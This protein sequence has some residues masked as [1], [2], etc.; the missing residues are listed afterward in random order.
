MKY[1]LSILYIFAIPFLLVAQSDDELIDDL[2]GEESSVV[3]ST[4]K[5]SRVINGHSV[6]QPAKGEMD[7]RISHR[8]GQ[9]NTGSYDLWGLDQA[10]IHFSLEYS[11]LD[12]LTIGIGR[13]SY[14]K[15]YD[16][17]AKL[18]ILK[19]QAGMPFFLSYVA[20]T[21]IVT[22]KNEIPDYE[23]KH[24]VGYVH[25]LLIARKFSKN[26]SLQ[27]S[28]TLVHKNL[29]PEAGM[30]NNIMSLGIGARY[31]LSKRLSVNAETFLTDFGPMPEGIEYHQPI[32]L[33]IDLETGG[34]VFQIMVTNSLP[35]REVG[36]ITETAGD[37]FKGD[38]HLG[39]NISRTFNL[40]K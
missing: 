2:L 6:E 37:F 31:K 13:S 5:T 32:S 3:S 17:Y 28:P 21:E 12:Y 25:Q 4:F 40:H 1:I 22:L 27:L 38:I 39:F 29:V 26:F 10:T 20:T 24:R 23:F 16:G 36:F 19:Q 18:A 34:H 35:M 14:R 11:P 15:T 7:F 33:G 9:L 8:F 30:K